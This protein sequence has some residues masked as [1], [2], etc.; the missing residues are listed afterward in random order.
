MSEIASSVVSVEEAELLQVET[1]TKGAL[2]LVSLA[3]ASSILSVSRPKLDQPLLFA[4]LD[5]RLETFE[6]FTKL[7]HT[8]LDL[9]QQ[10]AVLL[11]SPETASYTDPQTPILEI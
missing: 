11:Q 1:T 7:Y 6:G 5:C 2:V 8:L 10:H 3:F 4:V 9:A